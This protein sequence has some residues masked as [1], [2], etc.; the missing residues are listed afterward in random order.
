MIRHPVLLDVNGIAHAFFTRKDGVSDGIYA[1][2]NCG[3]G[4]GDSA[5]AVTENRARAAMQL[6]VEP[7][8]L[9]TAHQVH[10][11]E[12]SVVDKPWPHDRAPKADALVTTQMGIALGVLAADCAPVLLADAEAEVI[13]AAHAGWR[14]ALAGVLEATVAKMIELG[15]DQRRIV[16]AVG[17]C[18]G[19]ES[20]EVGPEFR[21]RFLA[22]NA[23]SAKQFKPASRAG[24]YLFD[25]A[26]HAM[27]RLEAMKVKAVGRV[28]HDTFSDTA[29]FY[30]Y[31][32][33]TRNGETDYGRGLS[34]I[35]LTF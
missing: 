15:A 1:S 14:G 10:G 21:D 26:G 22:D 18:I 16:A 6:G 33:A 2:L 30:S 19:P 11:T 7:K 23:A 5:A 17:P 12:V 20:Y 35:A 31:R 32:R 8:H 34:A 24:Y 9:V 25:L 4:S 13:A 3:F 28:P 29:R 27:W